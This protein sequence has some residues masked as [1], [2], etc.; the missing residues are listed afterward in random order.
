MKKG[1][2]LD[3]LIIASFVKYSSNVRIGSWDDVKTEARICLSLF[4]FTTSENAFN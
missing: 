4:V 2:T 1:N 3:K